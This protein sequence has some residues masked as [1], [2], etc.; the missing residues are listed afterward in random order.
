MHKWAKEILEYVQAKIKAKGL[1]NITL[2][3]L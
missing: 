2:A 1:D 3:E